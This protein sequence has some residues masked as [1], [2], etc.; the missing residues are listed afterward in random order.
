MVAYY[1]LTRSYNGIRSRQKNKE[2]KSK[3]VTLL[4][5]PFITKKLLEGQP[6]EYYLFHLFF[7][8]CLCFCFYIF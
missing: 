2:M 6:I 3:L 7:W 4:G 8:L 1:T 5:F